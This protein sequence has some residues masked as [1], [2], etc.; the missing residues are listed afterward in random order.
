MWYM[1]GVLMGLI[2]SFIF[3]R[4]LSKPKNIPRNIGVL[5]VVE[6]DDGPPYLFVELKE[7]A[8]QLYNE[9]V[10]TMDVKA[11]YTNSQK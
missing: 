7:S 9:R 1:I 8:Y 3:S 4:I 11:V 10:V 5:N 2:V 6:S